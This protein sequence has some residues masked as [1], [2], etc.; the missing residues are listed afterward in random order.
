MTLEPQKL[1]P[2]SGDLT[3]LPFSG[4][5]LADLREIPY[6]QDVCLGQAAQPLSTSINGDN[7]GASLSL[8]EDYRRHH[9]EGFWPPAHMLQVC[10]SP[11]LTPAV[12][13][14]ISWYCPHWTVLPD[15]HPA[16][17]Q[18]FQ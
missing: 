12:A 8:W 5:C 18:R 1:R 4:E 16:L 3:Q 7:K 13:S 17:G 14:V 10:R 2:S 15:H 11:L 9:A 6:F